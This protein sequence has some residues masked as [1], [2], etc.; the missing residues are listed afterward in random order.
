MMVQEQD[1]LLFEEDSLE[2]IRR[3]MDFT[4]SYYNP[5]N[6]AIDFMQVITGYKT[7]KK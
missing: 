6:V 3:Q 5:R 7:E 2:Y 4:D 1:V